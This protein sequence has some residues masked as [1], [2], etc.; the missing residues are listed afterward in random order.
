VI[1]K[2]MKKGKKIFRQWS[3]YDNDAVF[4]DFVNCLSDSYD[5]LGLVGFGLSVSL[6]V[7]V[8][9]LY[10]RV[11]ALIIIVSVLTSGPPPVAAQAL[12]MPIGT[13]TSPTIYATTPLFL[14]S[15]TGSASTGA[16]PCAPLLADHFFFGYRITVPHSF[17]YFL[18]CS[19]RLV[20]Y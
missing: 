18:C 20:Y 6:F 1:T 8:L 9:V 17:V 12:P 4:A 2:K 10:R 13:T 15:Q 5:V 19:Y 7:A 16:Q 3:P 14:P 11:R